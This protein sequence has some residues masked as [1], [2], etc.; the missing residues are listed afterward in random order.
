VDFLAHN[1]GKWEQAE[2]LMNDLILSK[3][4]PATEQYSKEGLLIFLDKFESVFIK[5]E[6][7]GQGRGIMRVSNEQ[8]GG[9]HIL[10]YSLQG[11]PI[12]KVIGNIEELHTILQPFAKFNRFRPY[13]I[14]EGIQSLTPAGQSLGIRVHVQLMNEK[15][16]VGGMLGKLVDNGDGIVNRHRGARAVTIRDLLVDYLMMDPQLAIETEEHASLICI[17]AAE[18]FAKKYPW[19]RDCGID[20]GIDASG[21]LWIF[22]LNTTP[23]VAF[24]YQLED[25]SIWRQIINNRKSRKND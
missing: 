1:I 6:S 13:I 7:G 4:F 23:S 15:W 20:L 10:G 25:K 9:T 5:P 17:Q 14:Q 21:K 12:D 8:G 3:S 18:V 16:V 2:L 24:F 11:K 19:I 22:E